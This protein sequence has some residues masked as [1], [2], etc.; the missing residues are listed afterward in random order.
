VSEQMRIEDGDAN[1]YVVHALICGDE[2]F[3]S[4]SGL[5]RALLTT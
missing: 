3:E 4:P 2:D 5:E 1:N